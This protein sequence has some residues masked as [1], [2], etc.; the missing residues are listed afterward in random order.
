MLK[1]T[2]RVVFFADK[3]GVAP[4]EEYLK[5][6][7]AKKVRVR[8]TARIVLLEENG[9]KMPAPYCAKLK[10]HAKLWEL[11]LH[12]QRKAYRIFYYF[13]GR[14]IVLLHGIVKK[15]NTTPPRDIELAKERMEELERSKR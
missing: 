4:V 14:T 8:M 2:Y 10:H 7:L 6:T 3:K 5:G 13:S 11:K 12:F 15:T 9:I 1:S